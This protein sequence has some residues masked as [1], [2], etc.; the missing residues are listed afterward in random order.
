MCEYSGDAVFFYQP[1]VADSLIASGA[2][3]VSYYID[4]NLEGSIAIYNHYW[5]PDPVF[6]TT[7]G[8][9]CGEASVLTVNKKWNCGRGHSYNY[10]VKDQRGIEYFKGSIQYLV[11]DCKK[12]ELRF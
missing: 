6:G 3:S 10:S 1:A 11:G 7:G 4:E 9:S 2:T 8:P 5:P 12:I